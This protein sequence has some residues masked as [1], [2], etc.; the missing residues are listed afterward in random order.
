MPPVAA[1]APVVG[2]E[3]SAAD[4]PNGSASGPSQESSGE[5]SSGAAADEA[6]GD[7]AGEISAAVADQSGVDEAAESATSADV[8]EG[9]LSGADA[10]SEAEDDEADDDDDEYVGDVEPLEL[11]VDPEDGDETP[12]MD[13]YILKVQVNREDSIRDALLRRVKIEGLER[14]FGDIVVPTE[15][16]AEFTKTGKRRV[17]K[18]KL[19]PGYIMVHMAINDDTWF[20]VRETPGI[21][22][23]TGSAG[24]PAPM[25]PADVERI[26]KLGAD[27][28][29]DEQQIKTAIPF[30]VGE[31]VRVKDGYFQNFEGDVEAVDETHG[32]V[33]VMINIFGRPTPVELEHWQ[34]EKI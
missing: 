8:A 2:S 6:G 5:V 31:R 7:L 3:A 29:E 4:A 28:D 26:L 27:E 9:E 14:Y 32:R 1:D 21:G 10:A 15:D 17:V 34:I 22:D 19:Y 24:R 11:L 23:F 33:T 20:V 30:S 18:K 13:W 12:A 16:I 25:D